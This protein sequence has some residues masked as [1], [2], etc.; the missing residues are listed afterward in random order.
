MACLFATWPTSRSPF[1]VKATTDGV[2]L[3]PSWL[4]IIVGSPACI[5]ATTELVVPRSIPITF[6]M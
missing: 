3:V 4:A 2:V 5:I 1:S 6:P